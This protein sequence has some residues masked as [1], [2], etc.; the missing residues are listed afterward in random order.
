MNQHTLDIETRIHDRR[1]V[2]LRDLYLERSLHF[3]TISGNIGVVDVVWVF[4]F[5]LELFTKN[6]TQLETIFR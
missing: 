1:L 4:Y 3:Y 5:V 6:W 2:E